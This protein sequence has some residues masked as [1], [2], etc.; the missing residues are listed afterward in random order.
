MSKSM[1]DQLSQAWQKCLSLTWE[2]YCEGSIP[3]A[4]ILVDPSGSIISSGRNRAYSPDSPTKEYISGSPLAH[5]ELNTLLAVDWS[6]F[7]RHSLALYTTVEPCPL[8]IG[9]VCMCGVKTIRYAARDAWSGST[10]LLDAS[11]YLKWKQIEA[12]PPQDPGLE[13]IIHIFQVD[14]QLS[15]KHPRADDV[16]SKWSESYPENVL[17]GRRIFEQGDLQRLKD[18]DFPIHKVVNHLAELAAQLKE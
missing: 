8:C 9:A 12:I 5:A 3:I 11:P 1:W 7:D 18:K 2:S 6:L 10:N 4:A 17:V 13:T 14:D 15:R 16:L